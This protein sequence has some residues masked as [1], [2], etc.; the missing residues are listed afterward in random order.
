MTTTTEAPTVPERAAAF[1]ERVANAHNIVC[2]QMDAT[3]E[4]YREESAERSAITNDLDH[5]PYKGFSVVFV[6]EIN[7]I[8][9]LEDYVAARKGEYKYAS[10][11]KHE[12]RDGFKW[13]LVNSYWHKIELAYMEAVA[14]K[15]LGD[16]NN[17][18]VQF[19]ARMLNIPDTEG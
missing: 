19:A 5:K 17:H 13:R 2:V 10:A 4:R 9:V 15:H 1:K 8:A 3:L 14:A 11:L 12:T 18:F 6:D 16:G 7:G